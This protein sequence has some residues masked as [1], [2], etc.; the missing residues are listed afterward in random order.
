MSRSRIALAGSWL[1][2]VL[3]GAAI[4]LHLRHEPFHFDA[5]GYVGAAQDIRAG[6]LGRSWG[7]VEIRTYGYPLMLSGTLVVAEALHVAPITVIFALQWVLLVGSAWLAANSL[8]Q[9]PR[10]RL[11]AFVAVA[12]NPLLVVYSA[13]AL[14]E[15]ATLPCI[16]FATAALGRSV[17]ARSAATSVGW[18]AAGAFASGFALAIRPGNIAVPICYVIAALLSLIWPRRRHSLRVTS[19]SAALVM[20]AV[21]V[22]IAPQ[23]WINWQHFQVI[24]VLP[25]ADIQSQQF[26]LGTQNIRYATNV[27]GCGNAMLTF[28][29]P[30]VN[31]VPADA[32]TGDIL[33]FYALNWPDGPETAALHLFSG[34]DPRPFLTYQA[35]FGVWYERILQAATLALLALACF[36]VA[37]APWSRR[38]VGADVVFLGAVTLFSTAILA[39]SQAELRF[40]L[41]PITAVSLLAASGAARLRKP[42]LRTALVVAAGFATALL[43]WF[44]LSDLVLTRSVDWMACR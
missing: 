11:L 2:V 44:A 29:T 34:L 12:A 27:A 20:A 33:R 36:G 38:R 30:F 25:V 23:A 21:L 1:L 17:H 22:P 35:S 28:T 6:E 26:V 13:Q 3:V 40:G 10:T 41:I 14:T 4:Y 15:A 42:S 7:W 19:I 8:F 9:A 5:A 39:T 31:D 16:L 32:S 18:L 43:L 37:R 24:S